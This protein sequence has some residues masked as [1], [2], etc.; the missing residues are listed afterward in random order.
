MASGIYMCPLCY[1]IYDHKLSDTMKNMDGD[2]LILNVP[3][4]VKNYLKLMNS[5]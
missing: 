4:E 5:W 1:K 3:V 2:V